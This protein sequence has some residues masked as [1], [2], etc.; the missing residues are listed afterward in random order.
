M[1]PTRGADGLAR[2]N[3]GLTYGDSGCKC[4]RITLSLSPTRL[5]LHRWQP[6]PGMAET[7]K[8]SAA[9]SRRI[10]SGTVWDVA[11]HCLMPPEGR[12]RPGKL[13]WGAIHRRRRIPGR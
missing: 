8:S 9:S 2:E 12:R 7:V 4:A 1:T 3:I 5:R 11:L 10:P 6:P 13:R